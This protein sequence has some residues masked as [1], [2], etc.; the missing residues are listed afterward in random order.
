MAHG[1]GAALENHVLIDI[2]VVILLIGRIIAAIGVALVVEDTPW[3]VAEHRAVL[4]DYD[5]EDF[6]A[7]GASVGDIERR[8]GHGGAVGAPGHHLALDGQSAGGGIHCSC[9]F[10]AGAPEV[11]HRDDVGAFGRGDDGCGAARQTQVV[12]R[13]LVDPLAG[14]VSR[15]GDGTPWLLCGSPRGC[16]FQR[17]A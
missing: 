14:Q 6:G 13:I 12:H 5:G 10:A 2:G 8:Y 9:D 7:Q 3:T 15:R 1:G 17:A 4:T 16:G 11:R